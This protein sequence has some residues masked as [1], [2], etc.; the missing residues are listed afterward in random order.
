MSVCLIDPTSDCVSRCSRFSTVCR[1]MKSPRRAI[2]VSVAHS[3]L[4]PL[5]HLYLISV[6]GLAIKGASR[7]DRHHG[8]PPV[9]AFH[10]HAASWPLQNRA[11]NTRKPVLH[12]IQKSQEKS[13]A[14]VCDKVLSAHLYELPVKEALLVPQWPGARGSA[15]SGAGG[16]GATSMHNALLGINDK[17]T[18]KNGGEQGH[19]IVSLIFFSFYSAKAR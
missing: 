17:R 5:T 10:G 18:E 11:C 8:P 19:R 12:A 3:D 6:C 7:P 2:A 1:R 14:L 13:T 9:P 15:R 16:R 4:V